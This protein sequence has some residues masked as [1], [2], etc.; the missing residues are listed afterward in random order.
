MV[1]QSRA[2]ELVMAFLQSDQMDQTSSYLQRGRQ[3][4]QLSSSELEQAWFKAFRSW[5][6]TRESAR[7]QRESDLSAEYRLRNLEIPHHLVKDLLAKMQEELRSY[8]PEN[9][10]VL[11]KIEMFLNSLD[12]PDA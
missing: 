4:Q 1:D 6:E 8:G 9:P 12:K 11:A 5:F 10:G 7:E 2:T 3:F